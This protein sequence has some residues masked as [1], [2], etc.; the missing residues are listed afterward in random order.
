MYRIRFF[1]R[2]LLCL[3][4]L[5]L[6]ACSSMQVVSI[7][8]AM[9]NSPP[10][11]IDFGSLVEVTTIDKKRV[12]FRVTEI[13]NDGLGGNK[14]Y[15]LYEDMKSLKRQKPEQAK[16]QNNAVSYILG[17]LG[18]IALVALISNADSVAVCSPS[19][20]EIPN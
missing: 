18:V 6:A 19:P 14:G 12:E 2:C 17:V 20:C 11:G 9:Q 13:G 1:N 5:N 15:Y 3:L 8:T 10:A 16:G 7:E 4:V